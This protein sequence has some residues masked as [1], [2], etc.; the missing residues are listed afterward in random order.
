MRMISKKHGRST[1]TSFDHE[2]TD[3][4]KLKIFLEVML[5]V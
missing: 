3:W 1:D 5:K 4:F 2:Y